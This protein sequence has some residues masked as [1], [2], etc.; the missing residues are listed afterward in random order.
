MKI[1][2]GKG[3]RSQNA[4][5]M[6]SARATF[7]RLNDLA[8][9]P[10]TDKQLAQIWPPWNALPADMSP[11]VKH[12][13]LTATFYGIPIGKE[14]L[15]EDNKR[16]KHLAKL[17]QRFTYLPL[18][19]SECNQALI[20]VH[21]W[22]TLTTFAQITF[23]G[24]KSLVETRMSYS[25]YDADPSGRVAIYRAANELKLLRPGF[26]ELAAPNLADI[27][28]LEN[29]YAAYT[30]AREQAL[31]A[32]S[33]LVF[34]VPGMRTGKVLPLNE[35]ALGVPN[36]PTDVPR[37]L[38]LARLD[39]LGICSPE[40]LKA[41]IRDELPNF[42]LAKRQE[43]YRMSLKP[44]YG[45]EPYA[46]LRVWLLENRPIFEHEQFAWQ[47]GDIQS[48]AAEKG[49]DCP[50]TSLKQWASR[51]RLGLRVKRGPATSDDTRIVRSKPLLSPAPVFG[52]VLKSASA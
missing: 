39:A 1:K 38:F 29:R 13:I 27:A 41:F 34:K 47:W 51:N 19:R 52:D 25:G 21:R 48:A 31:A 24:H 30:L 49:I 11:D 45:K 9:K 43:F 42:S 26:L 14:T 3:G 28:H 32:L 17:K 8:A 12:R 10:A 6:S 36:P 15:V 44:H 22:A 50:R 35:Q 40:R 16:Q 23:Q 18:D 20:M 5:L 2:R 4:R 46:A 37:H 33:K 7:Q